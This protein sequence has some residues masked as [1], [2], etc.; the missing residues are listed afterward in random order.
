[1]QIN[2]NNQK[3][4]DK[5]AF[6]QEAENLIG[7]MVELTQEDLSYYHKNII[8]NSKPLDKTYFDEN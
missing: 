6:I 1:M 5:P 7:E 2:K 4:H 8:E 3:N